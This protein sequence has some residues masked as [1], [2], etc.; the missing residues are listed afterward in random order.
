[1]KYSDLLKNPL[2]QRK[3]LEI[4]KRDKWKCFWCGDN[5]TTLHVHHIRYIYG[6]NPWEYDNS[7]F[8]T[9]CENC[10]ENGTS[11]NKFILL[12]IKTLL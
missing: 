2:W 5:T 10:H 4:M 3:R 7:N 8:I 1:M 9:L 11:I 6:R 12:T